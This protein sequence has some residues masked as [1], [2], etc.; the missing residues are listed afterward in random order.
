MEDKTIASTSASAGKRFQITK[1]DRIAVWLRST[2]MQ[3]SNNYERLITMGFTFSMAPLADRLYLR[4]EDRAAFLNRHLEFFNTHPYLAS[5]ILGVTM[6]LEEERANGADIDDAA[7]QGV[8]IGMMGPLAGVGD[9]VFWGTLRPILGAFAASLA[10]T[11]NVMGA[12]AFFVVWNAVRMGFTWYT[13]ELGYRQGRNIVSDLSGGIMQK[14]TTGASIL[15]MFV[16][17]VLIPRWTSINL[18][19]VVLSTSD[20]G[21]VAEKFPA[22]TTLVDLLNGGQQ[23]AAEALTNGFAEIDGLLSSGYTVLTNATAYPDAPVRLMQTTTFQ[24]VCDSLLPGLMPLA[25]T[26]ICLLLLRRKVNPILI[27]CGLF[28]VGVLG[29]FVGVF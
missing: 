21:A 4:R 20:M 29:A 12:V 3:A 7:I 9:P 18:S 27:I 13:Q 14:I 1:R 28:A 2:F 10:L 8:K 19:N 5:P 25:L 6:A 15:G 22:V 11:G 26:A 23:V 24:S 16:M 17:G